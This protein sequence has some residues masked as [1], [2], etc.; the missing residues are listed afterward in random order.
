MAKPDPDPE[1]ELVRLSLTIRA[2]TLGIGQNLREAKALCPPGT[3][4]EFLDA[5]GLTHREACRMLEKAVT[6]KTPEK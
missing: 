5:S 6:G 3:W 4:Q 2:A 1:V